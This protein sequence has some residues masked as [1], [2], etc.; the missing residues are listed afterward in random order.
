ML[1]STEKLNIECPACGSR[2]WYR[3]VN[4]MYFCKKCATEYTITNN[5]R[6]AV[7]FGAIHSEGKLT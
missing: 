4:G 5:A 2:S 3:K 1:N 7:I 6:D